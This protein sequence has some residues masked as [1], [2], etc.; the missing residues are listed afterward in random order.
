[1]RAGFQ[2]KGIKVYYLSDEEEYRESQPL[3][4]VLSYF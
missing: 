4:A 3:K 1:M 2:G